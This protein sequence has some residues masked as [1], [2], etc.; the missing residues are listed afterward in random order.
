[1][2]AVRKTVVYNKST[3]RP[4]LVQG[5]S[6]EEG[7][8]Y[9]TDRESGMWYTVPVEDLNDGFSVDSEDN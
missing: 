2:N 7:I 5:L 4:M 6:I 1:M 3:Q 8:V 9:V